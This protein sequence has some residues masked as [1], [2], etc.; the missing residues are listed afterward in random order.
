[1]SVERPLPA[2]FFAQSTLAVARDLL[3][4]RLVHETPT[5]RLVGRVVETEA[6]V[7]PDDRGSH[8]HR[9]RTRRTAVMFGPPGVAYVY[10]IYG[11]HHCF[12]VVT[13]TEG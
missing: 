8:A 12:N 3:G 2:D 5:G 6:Y 4:A 9:G 1:M 10:L 7:G 11:L 13:E